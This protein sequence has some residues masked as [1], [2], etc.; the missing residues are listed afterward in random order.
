MSNIPLNETALGALREVA[1]CRLIAVSV[2]LLTGWLFVFVSA[3]TQIE[4]SKDQADWFSRSG[5]VLTVASLFGAMW[6]AGLKPSL[7]GEGG[8]VGLEGRQVFSEV[9]PYQTAASWASHVSAVV[10]TIVWGYGNFFHKWLMG[11]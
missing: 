9:K 1:N 10:G 4:V 7:V 5:S 8:L 3:F 11:L 6:I 2:V